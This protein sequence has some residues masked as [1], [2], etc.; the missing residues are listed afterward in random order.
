MGQAAVFTQE[1][2]E[3]LLCMQFQRR[4]LCRPGQEASRLRSTTWRWLNVDWF[5]CLH[6]FLF[7]FFLI[8]PSDARRTWCV[9]PEHPSCWRVQSACSGR[10]S[11]QGHGRG[12][13]VGGQPLP[14]KVCAQ[15]QMAVRACVRA[16][17]IW[18]I[19][20]VPAHLCSLHVCHFEIIFVFPN[21]TRGTSAV[22]T[23]LFSL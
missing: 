17:T 18:F 2:C 5:M 23:S 16:R 9:E 1:Y 6:F 8:P 15:D 21:P 10:M 20:I 19:L 13:G 7:F 11:W 12:N 3:R 22:T 14:A 4:K